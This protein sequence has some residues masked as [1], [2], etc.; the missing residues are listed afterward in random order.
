M[1]MIIQKSFDF[2]IDTGPERERIHNAFSDRPEIRGKLI[3]LMDL[4][5]AE[6]WKEARKELESDWWQGRDEDQECP[7][8]EF[9]GLLH[10]EDLDDA[11]ASYTDLIWRMTEYSDIY[12]VRSTI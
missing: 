11:W 6:K 5:E 7:R 4:V 10:S 3:H 12:K 8:L 1:K 9:V 2:T